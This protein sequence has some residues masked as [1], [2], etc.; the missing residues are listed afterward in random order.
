MKFNINVI[1][2]EAKDLGNIHLCK[3]LKLINISII[4]I[5]QLTFALHH[6][7]RFTK[8]LPPFIHIIK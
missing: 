8:N 4:L 6:S 5:I 7:L 2:S 1:L 3:S